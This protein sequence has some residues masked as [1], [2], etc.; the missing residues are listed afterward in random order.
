MKY[1]FI[2]IFSFF[3]SL[4][5]AQQITYTEFKE[6][7]KTEINLQPEYGNVVKSQQE[8]AED[9]KFIDFVLKQDTTARKGSEDMVMLGFTYLYKG[10]LVTAMRRFNQAWLLD[11]K[12]EDAYWGF[13]S[14]Y[15]Y[16]NDEQQ[17]SKQLE[18]GLLINPNSPN[19]L[20][21][22]ATIY[23]DFYINKHDPNYLTKAID[24]FTRSY[25][26]DPNNQNTLFKLSAAY[27]YEKDCLNARKFYDECMKLGGK[28]ITPEYTEALNALCKR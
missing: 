21:D 23:M 11:P 19:L 27:Y 15:F 13:G 28:P 3:S 1:L 2:L 24:L 16:F 8:I 22:K 12:N 18:K 14:V 20:T 7:A 9:K 6:R 25:K 26:I 5:I 4:T 10:D 17:A